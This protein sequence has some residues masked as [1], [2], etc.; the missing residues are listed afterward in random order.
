MGKNEPP[1]LTLQVPEPPARPGD[2]PD[3]SYLKLAPAGS[4]DRPPVHASAAQ[5]HDYAYSLVRVLDDD[6]NAVGPW[7]PQVGTDLLRTGLRAMM[8]TRAFDTRM[9]L[10]Q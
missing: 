6:G 5:M 2:K 10:A 8:K 3:F 1:R 7:S 9:Q 4:V